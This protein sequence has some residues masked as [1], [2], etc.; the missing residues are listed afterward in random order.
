MNS[1]LNLNTA[2][3]QISYSENFAG[4]ATIVDIYIFL[5][6]RK[7]PNMNSCFQQI[8]PCMIDFILLIGIYAYYLRKVWVYALS[9]EGPLN[10]VI[11]SYW[12][13]S[14]LNTEAAEMNFN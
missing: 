6:P 2:D 12:V 10:S 4:I 13:N 14:F 7:W 9:S 1:V 5:F 3:R 11:L 8:L